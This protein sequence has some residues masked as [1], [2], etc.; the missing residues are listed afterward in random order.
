M[1]RESNIELLRI[2]AMLLVV[3]V[4]ANYYSLGG[5]SISEIEQTPYNSFIRAL[6][7]Q[8]CVI[9]VNVFVIISGWF[10]INPSLKGG[11]SL[12]FQV[13]FFHTVLVLLAICLGE[14]V[15]LRTIVNG[16]YFGSI[17]WFVIAYLI[18][19]S[20][21]PV[22]NSFINNANPRLYLSVLC[23]FLF[24]EFVFALIP[25]IDPFKSGYSAISFIGLYLLVQFVRKYCQKLQNIGCKQCFML[26]FVMSILPVLLFFITKYNFN[27]CAYSSPFVIFASLFFFL[28]FKNIHFYSKVINIIAYSS[29]SIYLIHMHPIVKPYFIQLMNSAY[30]YLGGYGYIL[31][32]IVFA[33]CLG[34]FCVLF[35]KLR[36]LLWNYI[37][38]TFLEKV[39]RKFT[40]LV[41]GIYSR[42]GF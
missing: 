1:K 28:A 41:D 33:I 25:N 20:I 17:Y 34:A 37:Y 21:S 16:Y 9:C 32:V 6:L 14:I 26:Y 27:I 36:V 11:L 39:I 13:F 38:D 24:M 12:L 29:F 7:E 22:L 10:G 15:S 19:Y 4:H 18:L 3:F 30:D 23:I 35:D 8:L 31:F 40:Y 2:V 5:V 42:I